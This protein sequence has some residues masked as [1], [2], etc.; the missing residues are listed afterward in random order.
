MNRQF[1]ESDAQV[2]IDKARELLNGTPQWVII[3]NDNDIRTLLPAAD[4]ARYLETAE[5]GE[6]DLLKIPAQRRELAPIHLEASM[7]QAREALADARVDALYVRRQIAPLSFRTFGVLSR[8]DI[9][10]SYAIRT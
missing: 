5:A 10:S 2:S 4:L 1:I 9:E 7:Q 8:Q 3:R 6:F